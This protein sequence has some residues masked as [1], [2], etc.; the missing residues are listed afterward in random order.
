MYVEDE[1][2]N[3]SVL[4]HSFCHLLSDYDM[5]FCSSFEWTR[6]RYSRLT[7]QNSYDILYN[8]LSIENIIHYYLANQLHVYIRD[9]KNGKM[10]EEIHCFHKIYIKPFNHEV[11]LTKQHNIR[12][13][14]WKY[15]RCVTFDLSYSL[16]LIFAYRCGEQWKG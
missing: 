5:Y 13:R 2:G 6:L 1:L 4:L 15:N 16:T 12:N 7:E 9:K 8:F 3:K 10:E 11:L 14:K